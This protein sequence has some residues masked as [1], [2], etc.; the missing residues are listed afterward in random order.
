MG[1][2]FETFLPYALM[3]GLFGVTGVGLSAATYYENNYKRPRHGLDRWDRQML[4][5]D[6]R[7]TGLIRGQSDKVEAPV[8]FEVNNPWKMEPRIV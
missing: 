4:E 6:Q 3:L 1:V 7:M 8:G 2:P 5:R